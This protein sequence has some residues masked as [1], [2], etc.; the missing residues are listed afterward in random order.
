[1]RNTIFRRMSTGFASRLS[2]FDRPTVWH[3]FTPLAVKHSAVNLGQGF[4]DWPS[5][6]FCKDALI[7]A[8]ADDYNQYCRA[9]GEINLVKSLAKEYSGLLRREIDPLTEVVTS[10]GA[11]ECLFA[12]MQVWAVSL[13]SHSILLAIN[14]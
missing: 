3:E 9:A 6:Q 11:T 7:K 4:P 2:G 10:V 5:P 1:M 12:I 14:L 8:V 13:S